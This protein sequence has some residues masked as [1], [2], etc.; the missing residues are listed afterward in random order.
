[1]KISEK[2]YVS[3]G[4]LKNINATQAIK[5]FSLGGISEIELSG[6]K[7][8][9]N[10]EK[11]I[12]TLSNKHNL[13]IHNYFPVPKKPFVINLASSNKNILNKSI[14]QAKKAINLA[15]K[16]NSKYYSF[17]AGFLIDP[18]PKLL[19]KEFNMIK[20]TDRNT[21]LKIFKKSVILL[22][23]IAKRKNV[24]I[25]I[26][27]NV[28]TK[29]NIKTFN[30][31]PLLLTNPK[32]ISDFFKKIPKNIRLLLDVAHLKVSAKTEGFSLSNSFKI[33]NNLTGGYHLSD[34]NGLVDSN[35]SFSSKTWFFKYIKKNL[36]YYTIEVYRRSTSDLKKQKMIVEN[37]LKK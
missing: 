6:G 35:E 27:N 23:K 31:N 36:E 12:I 29:K 20:I 33:L 30:S 8:Q 15:S 9:K 1:M 2:V 37:F 14:A 13:R 22:N 34:N 3:S 19:G 5:K 18:S 24:I 25:F 17:H 28:I 21:A 7:F 16:M 4:G 11:K 10:V 26:E 32:E